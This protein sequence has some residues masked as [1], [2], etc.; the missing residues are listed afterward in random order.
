MNN[1]KIQKTTIGNKQVIL[2]P[3]FADFEKLN[4][5]W[6]ISDGDILTANFREEF[7]I[8]AIWY[9]IKK[10]W[11]F[12]PFITKKRMRKRMKPWDLDR[13]TLMTDWVYSGKIFTEDEL[14]AKIKEYKDNILKETEKL[15]NE[16]KNK[17]ADEI[18]EIASQNKNN[19]IDS[20]KKNS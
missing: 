18:I 6:S 17:T 15:K 12:K 19:A 2:D 13:I 16:L 3:T 5:K 7:C 8:D 14:T 1:N 4:K 20:I 10:N 11:L 9:A